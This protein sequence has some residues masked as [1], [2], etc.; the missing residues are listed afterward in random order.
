MRAQVHV[1]PLN[2]LQGT[3]GVSSPL[4]RWVPPH[5]GATKE[6]PKISDQA[7][8]HTLSPFY[9]APEIADE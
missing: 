3:D 2:F 5:L 6:C 9:T 4:V 8:L 7:V 1:R